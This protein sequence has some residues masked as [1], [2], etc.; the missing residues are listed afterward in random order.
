[1]QAMYAVKRLGAALGPL[2]VQPFL[3]DMSAHNTTDNHQ[4]VNISNNSNQ[5]SLITYDEGLKGVSQVRYAYVVLASVALISS[6]LFMITFLM[7]RRDSFLKYNP[8]ASINTDET[9]NDNIT[10][11]KTVE[12]VSTDIP[13]KPKSHRKF[14]ITLLS[15]VFLYFFLYTC[16]EAISGNLVALFAVRRLRLVKQ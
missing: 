4:H 16:L 1:M 14:T 10:N 7:V 3:V 8:Y 9:T 11:D 12:N 13:S 2:V 15:L 6:I 5:D